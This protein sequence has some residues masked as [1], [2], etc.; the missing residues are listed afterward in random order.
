MKFEYLI[1][2][3]PQIVEENNIED[4]ITKNPQA[5]FVKEIDE[6]GNTDPLPEKKDAPV[7]E[8]NMA[9]NL[10]VGSSDLQEDPVPENLYGDFAEPYLQVLQNVEG[11]TTLT[12]PFTKST[13]D[14][15]NNNSSTSDIDKFFKN[16]FIPSKFT[17]NA[18]LKDIEDLNPNNP[19]KFIESYSD[20][21]KKFKSLDTDSQ[22]KIVQDFYNILTKD[23]N[24]VGKIFN[25]EIQKSYNE[26]IELTKTQIANDKDKIENAKSFISELG[27]PY[28]HILL[29]KKGFISIDIGAYGVP[30]TYVIDNTNNKIIKKYLGP[31]D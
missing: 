7:E 24:P 14:L 28:D 20:D 23:T 15:F 27:N 13:L 22:N 29:D 11:T 19:T 1:D 3:Q 4:F 26:A 25:N 30:E 17:Y 6:P 9:S 31:I 8:N 12:P 10:E 16:E 18:I 2:E 5:K 21:L